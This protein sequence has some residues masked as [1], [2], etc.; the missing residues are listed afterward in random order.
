MSISSRNISLLPTNISKK[1]DTLDFSLVEKKKWIKGNKLF[2][3]IYVCSVII[4]ILAYSLSVSLQY[5]PTTTPEYTYLVNFTFNTT[6]D[7]NQIY[8]LTNTYVGV[9]ISDF[10]FIT[11]MNVSTD[12]G[13]YNFQTL[14]NYYIAY[15]YTQVAYVG[16]SFNISLE[17]TLTPKTQGTFTLISLTGF[18]YPGIGDLV[19]ITTGYL[20]RYGNISQVETVE[21]LR[22]VTGYP[23][24]IVAI[25]T[26]LNQFYNLRFDFISI[27]NFF[28]AILTV[29][30][31]IVFW[32]VVYMKRCRI[33]NELLG[34]FYTT[35]DGKI[36]VEV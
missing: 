1:Y 18:Q 3:T 9:V 35:R 20:D 31:T 26:N 22:I 8:S 14:D 21:D 16:C 34:N 10:I 33:K 32:V 13:P 36:Y 7:V 30:W 29:L 6:S 23:N 27:G 17:V 15:L 19:L 5:K 11:I 24:G 12:C 2:I 28:L 4:A 25:D